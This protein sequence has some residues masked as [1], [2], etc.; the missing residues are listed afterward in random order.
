MFYQLSKNQNGR[1]ILM[2]YYDVELKNWNQVI[3][4]AIKDAGLNNEPVTVIAKPWPEKRLD[5]N[6]ST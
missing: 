3:E 5:M 6:L 1:M 4:Q 2:I